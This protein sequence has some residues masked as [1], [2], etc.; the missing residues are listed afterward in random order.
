M[1]IRHTTNMENL[2]IFSP[3]A[4]VHLSM[5][6]YAFLLHHI[7]CYKIPIYR[8]THIEKFRRCGPDDLTHRHTEELGVCLFIFK[9]RSLL[10]DSLAAS[11]LSWL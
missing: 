8:Q 10:V 5:A 6:F 4:I 2:F 7:V 1:V 9:R 11:A 3:N